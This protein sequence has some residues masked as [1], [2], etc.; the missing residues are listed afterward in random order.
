MFMFNVHLFHIS[1]KSYPKTLE[2]ASNKV[3]CAN[4]QCIFQTVDTNE[5]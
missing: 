2:I 4:V 5:R 3:K 1:E